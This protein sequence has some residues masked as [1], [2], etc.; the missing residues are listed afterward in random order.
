MIR[1]NTRTPEHRTALRRA[2][3]DMFGETVAA[4]SS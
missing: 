3:L 1:K 2:V 4:L